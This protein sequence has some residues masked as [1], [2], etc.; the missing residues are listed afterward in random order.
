M[1]CSLASTCPA[2]SVNACAKKHQSHCSSIQMYTKVGLNFSAN[3]TVPTLFVDNKVIKNTFYKF[4][5]F[6]VDMTFQ[7]YET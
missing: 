1:H 5:F 3:V 6:Q 2:I 7:G 4:S